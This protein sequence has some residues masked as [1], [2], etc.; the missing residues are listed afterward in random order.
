MVAG[1][2]IP[3]SPVPARLRPIGRRREFA[4]GLGSSRRTNRP[5]I[6]GLTLCLRVPILTR[7]GCTHLGH[8][9]RV[10]RG[11]HVITPGSAPLDPACSPPFRTDSRRESG[12]SPGMAIPSICRECRQGP[13][14]PRASVARVEGSDGRGQGLGVRRDEDVLAVADGSRSLRRDASVLISNAFL[15]IFALAFMGCILA[16][17][18]V[19]RIAVWAG[20]IDR[21]DQFRR[22][23]KGATPRLGGLGL[24]FGVALAIILFVQGGYLD[25]WPGLAEWWPRQGSVLLAALDRPGHR[26]RRRHAEHGPAR[27][28]AGPGG[29]RARALRGRHPH[30]VARPA[31]TDDR[32]GLPELRRVALRPVRRGRGA[33]PGWSRCSG[34]WAA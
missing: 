1:T 10:E 26:R 12:P 18:L 31:G 17:P 30:P 21:P 4:D 27:E 15:L 2:P 14:S 33:L 25:G 23:H 8:G 20:A 16:T 7:S 19:T 29:R 32:P 3:G 24:A 34:S 22:I 28:A 13:R 5:G 6:S 9:R 11:Y